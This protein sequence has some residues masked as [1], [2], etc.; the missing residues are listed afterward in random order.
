M[1]PNPNLA[2]TDKS[3]VT[4]PSIETVINGLENQISLY[5]NDKPNNLYLSIYMGCLNHNI[6]LNDNFHGSS[7]N[8]LYG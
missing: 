6:T 4:T 8:I 5:I 1:Y 2:D 3:N 7:E